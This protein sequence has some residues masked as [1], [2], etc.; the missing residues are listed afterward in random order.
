MSEGWRSPSVSSRAWLIRHISSHA[1]G[2]LAA[3]AMSEPR[4]SAFRATC[5]GLQTSETAAQEF[6]DRT[7]NEV[8]GLLVRVVT[9]QWRPD[10]T[11]A[12]GLPFCGRKAG[13]N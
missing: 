5:S 12:T 2:G 1:G 6:Y 4:S 10:N 11:V 8:P 3:V 13:A 7:G 9:H